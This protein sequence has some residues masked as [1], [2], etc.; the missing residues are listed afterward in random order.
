MTHPALDVVTDEGEILLALADDFSPIAAEERDGVLT[1]YFD[2]RTRRD[3][4][5]DALMRARPSAAITPREVDDGDWARRSQANLTP[6][7]VGRLTIAPPW[8]ATPSPPPPPCL[9]W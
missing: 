6:V 4:A 1:I 8:H 2:S 7:T 9:P 3:E 5:C